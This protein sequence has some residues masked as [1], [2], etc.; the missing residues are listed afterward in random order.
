MTCSW[1]VRRAD[2]V[3]G[4]V[5]LDG[6]DL[7]DLAVDQ[8]EAAVDPAGLDEVA[9]P[10]RG[11]VAA[12]DDAGLGD[13]AGLDEQGADGGRDGG[14]VL[15]GRGDDDDV[16][17]GEPVGGRGAGDRGDGVVGGAGVQQPAARCRTRATAAGTSVG[18]CRRAAA[19]R[20]RAPRRR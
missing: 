16:L 20:R 12:E 11:L 3:E 14:G 4:A 2:D 10:G 1:P 15:V 7:V 17:A 9:D 8:A 13:D 18:A 5:G 6:G 19:A